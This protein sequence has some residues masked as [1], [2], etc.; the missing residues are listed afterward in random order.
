MERWWDE[1]LSCGE[2][3]VLTLRRIFKICCDLFQEFLSNMSLHYIELFQSSN[4]FVRSEISV[5]QS[6]M[7]KTVSI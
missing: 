6:Q 1:N 5:F 3:L 7:S 2:C 4:K